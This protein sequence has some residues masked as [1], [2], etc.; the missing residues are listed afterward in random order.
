MAD[1]KPAYEKMIRNEGGYVLHK[2]AGD[3]GG[4][5]FAGISIAAHPEWNGWTIIESEGGN[6]EK[7]TPMVY[8]FYKMNY[9]DRVKGDQIKSQIIAENIF[10]FA[11]NA[12]VR[13][14]SKLAQVV[15]DA[16]PDGIIGN[17]TVSA[18]NNYNQHMFV[19]NY[20][21]SKIQRYA[22]ICNKNPAQKKFLLGWINRTLRGVK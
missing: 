6:S 11:V 1:F 4:L 13:T 20:A 12:G 22:Q 18:L 9:W 2:V 15:V 8:Q 17:N 16:T 10:D 21:L 3:T 14:A 7:L 19:S 5:T